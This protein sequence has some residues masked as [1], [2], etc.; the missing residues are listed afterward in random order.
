[1]INE[2]SELPLLIPTYIITRDDLTGNEKIFYGSIL[3]FCC[4]YGFCR[5]SNQYLAMICHKSV[6]Q[7]RRYLQKLIRVGLLFIEVDCKNERKI[8]TKETWANRDELKK[9]FD[10]DFEFNKKFAIKLK[11]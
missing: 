1:M 11:G 3:S 9:S 7:I 4:K 8:W 10:K 6:S 2:K 5:E